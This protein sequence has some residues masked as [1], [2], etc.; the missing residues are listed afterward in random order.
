MRRAAGLVRTGVLTVG[1]ALSLSLLTSCSGGSG[2]PAA[3]APGTPSQN[4]AVV[5]T[6]SPSASPSASR[7]ASAEPLSPYEGD[8]A[9]KAL[10][11]HYLGAALGINRK[12]MHNKQ[13]KDSSTAR[14][15][16]V[17]TQLAKPEFGTYYPGP[18]P[19]TPLDVTRV[20]ATERKVVFCGVETGWT[21]NRKGGKPVAK[22]TL[23]SL[24]G[25]IVRQQGRWRV[26][27][28]LYRKDSCTGV[29]I[30]EVFWS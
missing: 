1:L 9:V 8:P 12:N 25:T 27:Q 13:L 17:M 6:T 19:F 5:A 28:L 16:G 11:L 2:S 29:E 7:S 24:E 10:R 23:S 22:R 26:S 18:N 14:R 15:Y 4:G 3:T 21:L 30:P 20:S